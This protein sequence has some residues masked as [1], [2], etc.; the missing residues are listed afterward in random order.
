[1]RIKLHNSLGKHNGVWY[2]FDEK[3][4][5]SHHYHPNYLNLCYRIDD[6]LYFLMFYSDT[7][8]FVES[9][10]FGENDKDTDP[11]WWKGPKW[12]WEDMGK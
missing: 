2:L 5:I 1:M 10:G 7:K 9:T 6:C 11:D 12:N 8:E 4:I 3:M